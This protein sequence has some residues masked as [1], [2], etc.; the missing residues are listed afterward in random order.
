MTDQALSPRLEVRGL[1]TSF[2]TEAGR[3]QS[4]ADVSFSIRPGETLALVGE[5]GSGK[6]VTSLTLMGLHAKTSHAQV[7]GE[8]W[9]V[10]RDGQRVNLLAM[11]EPEK[12]ALRGNELG[13]IF[14]EPM[15]SL[16]PVLTIGEQ[17]AESVRLHLGQDRKSAMAHAQRMLELVEI[18]AA[19]QRVREYPHQ[20][21]GGMRQRVMIALAMACNPTLLIADEPTTALDVTI[22]AQI[23]ALMGRLQKETGMS[24]LFV[25]HNL[26][27]V[28]QY[29]DAVAV[30][31]GGRI[32][33][34]APVHDLFARP[35]H[36]YTRGLLACLPG[37]ARQRGTAHVPGKRPQ[38]VAIA[39]QVSSPL[40]PPPGCAF[41]P[42][43]GF[44]S[45]VCD[46]SMPKLEA[47][48]GQRMVRCIGFTEE[49]AA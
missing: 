22:Q 12:R 29:A 45:D 10:R 8:A 36:P 49:L 24:M 26:G 34:A 42:R 25:T 35:E 17:I 43:C 48:G 18:P 5:S 46:T 32:V 2:A 3:I 7:Q 38:L 28:A 23:L 11:P 14:Q 39:G 41:A 1:S 44:R 4:V 30:M 20:L 6:S 37:V 21:S 15:T 40:A 19:A 27:V 16:N 13:M 9:F 33:E 31:Y 47:S